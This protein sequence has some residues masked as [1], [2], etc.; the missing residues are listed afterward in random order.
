VVPSDFRV[1]A[2]TNH[3]LPEETAAGRFRRDLYYRLAVERIH[4][5]PLRDHAEDIPDLARAFL[6]VAQEQWEI[7]EARAIRIQP[8]TLD[9]LREHSWPGNVRELKNLVLRAA[10]RTSV[11]TITPA[12]AKGLLGESA[13]PLVGEPAA[14]SLEDVERE[15]IRRAL[16]DSNG[17]RRAAA[18]RLGISESTL[19]KRIRRY[20]LEHVG[21][22]A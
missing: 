13:L 7:P 20:G 6:A 3:D 12:I 10:A 15:A 19:Y 2:A 1:I 14:S 8:E 16:H 11:G 18:R 5:P 17:Q 22:P 21:L 4:L 9:V